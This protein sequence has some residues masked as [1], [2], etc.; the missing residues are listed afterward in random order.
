M[1][2]YVNLWR[3]V[4]SVVEQWSRKQAITGSK[5]SQNN[6]A[7]CAAGIYLTSIDSSLLQA[8][9]QHVISDFTVE[10]L[11]APLLVV[12]GDVHLVH[13]VRKLGF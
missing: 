13:C 9:A 4:G 7:S 10:G 6:D 8:S 11:V 2:K 3:Q 5:L 12:D 1:E